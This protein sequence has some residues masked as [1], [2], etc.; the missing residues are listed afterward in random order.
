MS[1]KILSKTLK[2]VLTLESY[3][4]LKVPFPNENFKLLFIFKKPFVILLLYW[5]YIATFTE[6]LKIY[7]S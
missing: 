4:I 3:C 5:E 1:K 6:V 7:H 2:L